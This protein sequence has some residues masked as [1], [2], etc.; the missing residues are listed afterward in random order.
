VADPIPFA[1]YRA[2]ESSRPSPFNSE[3]EQGFLG[4]LLIENGI[5]GAV[6]SFLKPEH[7]GEEIHR[8]IFSVAGSLSVLAKSRLRSR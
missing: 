7:F 4:T 3:L 1:D 5:F 8:R 6:G 2:R